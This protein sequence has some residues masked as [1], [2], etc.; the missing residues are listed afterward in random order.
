MLAHQG[1]VY[2]AVQ[3][4]CRTNEQAARAHFEGVQFRDL[5]NIN[6]GIYNRLAPLL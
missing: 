6:Q 2:Q 4:H 3:G 1:Y 5:G